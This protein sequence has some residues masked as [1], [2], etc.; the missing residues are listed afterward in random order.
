MSN[1]PSIVFFGTP[2]F[3]VASLRAL[4]ESGFPIKGVVTAP[5]RPAG[6]GR[7]LSVSPVKEY[8]L[9]QDLPLSQ[10]EKLRDENFLATLRSWQADLFVVV[11]F[12]MLPEAVWKMP[13][14]GTFNLHASLLPAYRGAAPINWAV[15]N[16]EHTTGVTS[17]FINDKIDTGALLLQRCLGVGP[18]ETAGE[19][20]DRLMVL[21]AETVVETAELLGLGQIEPK[22]QPEGDN[23]PA[24]PK[25]FRE[26]LALD[27]AK[28]P[29]V[30]LRHILGM[31]PYPGAFLRI[32]SVEPFD[33]K[34]L[35]ARPAPEI[36]GEAVSR[37]YGLKGTI[38]WTMPGGTLILEEVQAP[39][40]RPMTA[41]EWW[42]GMQTEEL[43]V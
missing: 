34:I 14:L 6:R 27:P 23:W 1:R 16:G 9:R 20:H 22:P 28:G 3:A 12:R 37:I 5:D 33:L 7:K 4:Y 8:A 38:Y 30:N 40:K 36:A 13:P 18:L 10:P 21:G 29:E 2:D 41:G 24:A 11:A 26:H 17:F 43:V 31:S 32:G 42:R 25:I 39:G 15:V 35:R 19:L